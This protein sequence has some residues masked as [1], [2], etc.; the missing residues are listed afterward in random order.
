VLSSGESAD[1]QQKPMV[2]CVL[3]G[4]ESKNLLSCVSHIM[5][6]HFGYDSSTVRIKRFVNYM[7]HSL[8][9]KASDNMTGVRLKLEDINIK[10]L[11]FSY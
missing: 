5:L 9:G 6:D 4:Y 2:A 10:K 11:I 8:T 7:L 1:D 3:C